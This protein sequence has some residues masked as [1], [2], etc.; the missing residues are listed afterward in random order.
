MLLLCFAREFSIVYI[1]PTTRLRLFYR[2]LTENAEE[3]IGRGAMKESMIVGDPYRFGF[4]SMLAR[5]VVGAYYKQNSPGRRG[6]S[7]LIFDSFH[8]KLTFTSNNPSIGEV[9]HGYCQAWEGSLP[10]QPTPLAQI[11]LP[12][13]RT[14]SLL[15]TYS[16]KDTHSPSPI[17][18][19]SRSERH[20]KGT[21][22]R[23]LKAL[24]G[25]WT[26]L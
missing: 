3:G 8:H 22:T 26:H 21:A 2:I 15:A 24:E 9:L 18:L 1:T 25:P 7:L 14:P 10:H 16:S 20:R 5:V 12:S 11:L 4:T 6:L 13:S 19:R 23:T 17:W